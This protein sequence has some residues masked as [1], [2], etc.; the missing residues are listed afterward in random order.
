MTDIPKKLAALALGLLIGL[1]FTSGACSILLGTV[2]ACSVLLT[3]HGKAAEEIGAAGIIASAG[4]AL[5]LASIRA[6]R[7]LEVLEG[8]RRNDFRGFDVKPAPKPVLPAEEGGDPYPT[9]RDPPTKHPG[10]SG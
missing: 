6:V 10:G 7:A 3:P 5:V 9:L 1:L 4:V 8:K 2:V